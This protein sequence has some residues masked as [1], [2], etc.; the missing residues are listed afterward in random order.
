[1]D[2]GRSPTLAQLRALAAVA[3]TL[4]FGTAAAE[5]GVSQP[6]VSAAISSLETALGLVL[7]ERS[8]RK[9]MLT[10][11]GAEVAMHARRVLGAL[12]QLI[13]AASRGG[14][15]FAGP[16]RLGI[17][18]TVAPY[19]MLPLLRI[20]ARR[21]PDLRPDVREDQTDHLLG[22]L[23][24]G[25]ADLL[26]LALPSGGADVVE[27]PL[28]DEDFV[29]LV[30][31][32]DPLAGRTRLDPAVLQKVQLLLLEE[33]HCLRD[34]ALDL[35][36]QVGAAT[37]HPARA[38]SLTTLSQLVAAGLGA[39]LLPATAVAVESRRGLATATFRPPAPGRRIGFVHRAG[40]P[41]G[42]EFAEIAR[43]L[44]A[45][46]RSTAVPVRTVEEDTPR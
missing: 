5:L 45:G 44:R 9:V 38:A 40:S 39:T 19:V 12:D 14:R 36:R 26:L 30:P 32:R 22:Q 23:A 7:V 6:S 25:R 43:R 18:P 8:T 4:H 34:Q 20:L 17:I 13:D 35:C 3:D 1:M 21:F 28:Y 42:T 27:L 33:G 11:A 46:I 16:L 37:D 2:S 24:A 10:P 15:P 41:R 29:L 31:E